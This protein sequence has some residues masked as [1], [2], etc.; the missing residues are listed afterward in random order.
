MSEQVN[1]KYPH[2]IGTRFY[3]FHPLHPYTDGNRPYPLKL[4]TSWTIYV[5]AISWINS[6]HTAKIAHHKN[7]H[8][9]NGHRQHTACRA[10]PDVTR[11]APSQQQ[12][13]LFELLPLAYL[14]TLHFASFPVSQMTSLHMPLVAH[15][16]WM[17]LKLVSS[18]P[19]A[20]VVT[21]TRLWYDSVEHRYAM[22]YL[23]PRSIE[24]SKPAASSDQ[25]I[26]EVSN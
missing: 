15:E 10:I 4:H 3:N 11:S 5:G 20:L 16:S 6:N 8:V 7:L 2:D 17:Q 12:P 13:F 18:D 23:R 26:N 21:T 25:K 1:R 14:H 24:R 22:N 9:W 19:K